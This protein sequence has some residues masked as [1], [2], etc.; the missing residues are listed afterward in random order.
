M[1]KTYLFIFL[2][3]LVLGFSSC[4]KSDSSEPNW[5]GRDSDGGTGKG[6]SYARFVVIGNHL[7]SI[8]NNSLLVY[9]LA[10]PGN[11]ELKNTIPMGD[12]FRTVETLFPFN[13]HLLFGTT[14]G[15]LVYSLA[16]PESPAYISEV[17]HFL[18]C[19]PVVAQGNYAYVTLNGAAGCRGFINQLDI[20]DISDFFAPKLIRSIQMVS[21]RGLGVDG[22]SLFVCDGNF[23]KVLSIEDPAFPSQVSQVAMTNP[24]DVI[25]HQNNLIVSAQEGIF[26]YD[27]SNPAQ[28]KLQ[29]QI[30]KVSK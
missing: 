20:M 21:P 13:G 11:P 1:K 28:L 10:N 15:M 6:G 25:P 4:E 9:S 30:P 12:F 23:L 27:Y 2:F 22:N 18:A 17:E 29:S 7:Y 8:H 19:D 26:Q 16:N 5:I 14:N 24:Y 3:V